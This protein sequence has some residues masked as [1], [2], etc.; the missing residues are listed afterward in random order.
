MSLHLYTVTSD[1]LSE[2]RYMV[3]TGGWKIEFEI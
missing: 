1:F 2:G 3:L